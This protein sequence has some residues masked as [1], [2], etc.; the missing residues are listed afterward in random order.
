MAI[1]AAA[2]A[3]F[4]LAVFCAGGFFLSLLK[5]LRELDVPLVR[6]MGSR[7]EVARAV[8]AGP[9]ELERLGVSGPVWSIRLFFLL[10]AAMIAA[11]AVTLVRA[12][13]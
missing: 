7:P 9:A 6:H 13:F 4:F 1:P 3:F 12:G 2:W 11:F 8:W 5:L 10:E